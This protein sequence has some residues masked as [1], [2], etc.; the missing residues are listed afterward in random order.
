MLLG[1]KTWP[2]DHVKLWRDL[3][4]DALFPKECLGCGRESAW[5]CSDCFKKIQI[6]P[7]QYCLD[8]KQENFQGE[9]CGGC[10]QK[11]HIDGVLIAGDY[12]NK[13]LAKLI[14][15]LKYHFIKEI[16]DDLGIY[17]ANFLNS[18]MQQ[19]LKEQNKCDFTAF[20]GT[21]L[22]IPVPL[23]KKRL[24]WRGFNQSDL[25]SMALANRS[26]FLL[27][28]DSLKRHRYTRP[29]AQLSEKKRWQNIAESFSWQGA[30][31]NGKNVI[32]IDDV[33]TTGATLNECA[34]ILK[35]NGAKKVW[36]LVAA[37][38]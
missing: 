11:Y 10:R 30:D 21:S 15:F 38:G 31:L 35:I 3:F 5:V 33:V 18:V 25:I 17:L 32:L 1:I 36:G 7:C 20:I 27:D 6:K 12:E 16:A 4:F 26:N 24:R 13:L 19:E 34:R 29:Q 14:K 8:C 28:H 37:K 9:F 22:M 23:D 2:K